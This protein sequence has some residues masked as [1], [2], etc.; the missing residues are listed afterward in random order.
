M[1]E[2]SNALSDAIFTVCNKIISSAKFDKTY[3]CRVLGKVSEGKYLIIKDNIEHI[4][5]GVF[6]YNENDIVTVL[7]PENNWHHAVIVYPQNLSDL[8]SKFT[9]LDNDIYYT[10][11]SVLMGE[12][13]N[14]NR[15]PAWYFANHARRMI[16]EFKI[17]S[18]IGLTPTTGS[19][20]YTPLITIT[21]WG[22]SSGGYPRQ[23]A[24]TGTIMQHR[25][26]IS[27]SEWGSWTTV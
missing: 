16:V 27:D 26:G 2:I 10:W 7:L 25:V 5:S 17:C 11:E 13:R 23:I 9:K 22:D 4:V 19:S 20:P 12:T 15:N 21:P 24:W 8:S 3:K 6:E 1:R 14:D 18:V